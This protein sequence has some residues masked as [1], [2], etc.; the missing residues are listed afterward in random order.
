MKQNKKW[1]S[2]RYLFGAHP[3]FQIDG[4]LGGGADISEMLLQGHHGYIEL[5]PALPVEWAE[6]EIKGLIA[7][8]GFV[9]DTKRQTDQC[10]NYFAH[11]WRL[12]NVSLSLSKALC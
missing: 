5:L 12:Q 11:W 6:G 8:G 4:N 9:V 1:V 10:L 3:S 2:S 7:S